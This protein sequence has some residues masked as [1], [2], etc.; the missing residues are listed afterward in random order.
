LADEYDTVSNEP[1]NPD[2]PN[3]WDHL[4][5]NSDSLLKGFWAAVKSMLGVKGIVKCFITGVSPLSMADHTSGFNIA[6]YVSWREELS[7]LCGLTENGVNAALNLLNVSKPEIDT[8][9]QFDIMKA[10]YNG[11]IFAPSSKIQPVFNTNTCLEYLEVSLNFK[12]GPVS[13]TE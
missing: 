9:Q 11:Y 1:L 7:G 13:V 5:M 12:K 2:D 4:R 8:H 3:P 6:T 10:N